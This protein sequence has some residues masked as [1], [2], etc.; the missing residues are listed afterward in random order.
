MNQKASNPKTAVVAVDIPIQS[1]GRSSSMAGGKLI[2]V[3]VSNPQRSTH[4]TMRSGPNITSAETSMPSTP[5]P[6]QNA[7]SLSMRD[8]FRSLPATMIAT[9]TARQ[10]T[11][12]ASLIWVPSMR[13]GNPLAA[14]GRKAR[15]VAVHW[16]RG[17]Q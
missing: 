9:A 6:N 14:V 3:A 8:Q 2:R 15:S 7:S 17:M 5:M 1:S 13:D 4:P 11:T 16:N 10:S 12:N